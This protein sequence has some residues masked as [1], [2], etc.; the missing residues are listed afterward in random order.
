MTVHPSEHIITDVLQ[1]YIEIFADIGFL[2][3]DIEELQRELVR[4]RIVKAYPLHAGNVGHT[5][6]ELCDTRLSIDVDTV[7]SQFLLYNLKLLH[8]LA[9]KFPHLIE[10]ILHLTASVRSRDER[11]GTVGAVAIAALRNLYV[12]IVVRC[13]QHAGRPLHGDRAAQRLRIVG[14]TDIIEEL[15]IVELPVKL[16]DLRYLLSQLI[17]VTLRQTAHDI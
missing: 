16:V 8:A 14:R 13:C 9:D 3:Y 5:L 2:P 11:N 4:V 7:V 10:Y 1:G 17:A 6:Y 15:V 12:G